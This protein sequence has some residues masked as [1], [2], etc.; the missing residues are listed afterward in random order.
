MAKR[1]MNTRKHLKT[2]RLRAAR[3]RKE[4]RIE[5]D[6]SFRHKHDEQMRTMLRGVDR[7]RYKQLSTAATGFATKTS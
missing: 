7:E 5:L 1:R 2:A 3:E 6:T 4:D